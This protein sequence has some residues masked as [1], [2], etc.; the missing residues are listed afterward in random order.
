[1]IN[2][3]HVFWDWN[4]TLLDDFLA[5]YKAVSVSLRKRNLPV[6]DLKTHAENFGFP[7]VRYYEFLGFDFSK[8]SYEAL[9]DEYT[10]NY[11]KEEKHIRAGAKQVLEKLF[12][13]S[14]RQY[15]LSASERNLLVSGLEKNNLGCYFT[16]IIALDNIHAVSKVEAGK[17]YL[18]ENPLSGRMLMVGDTEHDAEVAKILNMDCV[19]IESGNNT[20]ERLE[21]TGARIIDSLHEL[22]E[23]VLGKKIKSGYDYMTP[24]KAERRSFDLSETNRRFKEKYRDY[25]N[26][27]KNTNKTEDW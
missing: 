7:V 14:V 20:R 1:M 18:E 19:L 2:Y 13:N 6:P 27:V 11:L 22:E 8:V 5:G 17:K 12:L 15:V 10:E 4:G 23:I 9:A 16:D 24:E 25:Y 21:K 3:E 26:D